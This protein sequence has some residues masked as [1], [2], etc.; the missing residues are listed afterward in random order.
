M[1]RAR[2]GECGEEGGG[3]G[4]VRGDPSPRRPAARGWP[5]GQAVGQH[6]G[7]G[8]GP[9][10]VPDLPA[11][12]SVK[13]RTHARRRRQAGGRQERGKKKKRME[14]NGDR[15]STADVVRARRAGR[16]GPWRWRWRHHPRWPRRPP[17]PRHGGRYPGRPP[18]DRHWGGGACVPPAPAARHPPPPPAVVHPPA[19]P[20]R[21]LPSLPATGKASLPPSHCRPQRPSPTP[22]LCCP[23]NASLT[24]H[25]PTLPLPRHHHSGEF[26]TPRAAHHSFCSAS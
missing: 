23:R 25:S 15:A 22:P 26:T 20:C 21:R 18:R 8:G 3:G 14:S 24:Q 1:G 11:P 4:S 7:D 2:R 19:G 13:S 12:R 6:G 9:L 5:Q 10:A 16:H 17:C